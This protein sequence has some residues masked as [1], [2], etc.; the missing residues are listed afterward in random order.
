M[1]NI[2]YIVFLVVIG[3]QAQQDPQYTQYMYNMNVINPAYAGSSES[4]SI[5]A[6]YRSQWVG[7]EGS[8]STGTLS[9]HSPVGNRVGLGLS[10]INDEVGPVR[11]TNAYVDFSYTLPVGSITKL[12]FG[13]KAGATFHDIGLTSIET[14]DADDPFFSQDVNETT[15]NV[16]AGMYLYQ[17]NRWYLSASMPN[18]LNGTH[19]DSDGR[20]IGSET[21]HLFAAAG[22]VFD[23]SENFKLK[24]HA[25][26]KF[27]FDAPVSY[28]VNLNLFM[29]DIVE[30]GGGYR[31][32]DS[33]SG[34]VNFMVSPTLRI[35]YAYDAIQSE[36]NVVT[37]ASHEIFINFDIDL[38]RKV[39][40]SPRYF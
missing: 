16:G 5:G 10:L 31:L 26:M 19:L 22:Y 3:V 32:D 23:L 20:K 24:P 2:L 14:I 7:L 21:E 18:I 29:Y 30:I 40:R 13:L 6:L 36:L 12:A 34:M 37:D 28:D 4:V 27:A 25:L 33:F 11:E 17:P 39:S 15:A 9:I 1:K 38:P 8:P 35:G